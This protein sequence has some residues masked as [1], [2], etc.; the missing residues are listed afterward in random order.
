MK[1]YI[2]EQEDLLSGI[3]NNA[4]IMTKL[5]GQCRHGLDTG[6]WYGAGN[7][8]I[9]QGCL[10]RGRALLYI[11]GRVWVKNVRSTYTKKLYS[12][13]NPSNVTFFYINKVS[14]VLD[15]RSKCLYQ[16]NITLC[17]TNG[18]VHN[19]SKH[20]IKSYLYVYLSSRYYHTSTHVSTYLQGLFTRSGKGVQVPT[21]FYHE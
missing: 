21:T 6:T 2:C 12:I 13:E 20:H 5:I 19:L 17:H 9:S 16:R 18:C 8:Q 11:Y 10:V 7:Q 4:R 14:G 15:T 1:I 3:V